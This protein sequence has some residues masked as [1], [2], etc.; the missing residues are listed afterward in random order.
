MGN[1]ELFE[2]IRQ[3][4]VSEVSFDEFSALVAERG[5]RFDRFN[6]DYWVFEHPALPG[7]LGVKASDGKIQSFQALY[8]LRILDK[9]ELAGPD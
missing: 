9:H 8:L 1:R 5:F 6:E 4:K 3:G 7:T 2:R